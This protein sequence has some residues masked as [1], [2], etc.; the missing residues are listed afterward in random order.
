[1]LAIAFLAP[2]TWVGIY[3]FLGLFLRCFNEP[4]ATWRY[5]SDGAYWMYIIHLPIAV[6]LAPVLSGVDV[7][8]EL[9]FAFVFGATTV[10]CLI[11]YHFLVRA[12]FLGAWLN[13][14]KY[15][16]VAP[17]AAGRGRVE[18]RAGRICRR[19]SGKAAVT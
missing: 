19:A 10:L 17:M 2:A 15:P 11:T 12:T 1:M 6:A 8:A 5:I 9:K 4:N 16:R 14:R 13:G 7:V 18:P 3:A